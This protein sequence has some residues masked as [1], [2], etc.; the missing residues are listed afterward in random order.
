MDPLPHHLITEEAIRDLEQDAGA[1]AC[2]RIGTDRA[3]MREIPQDL[4]T[5]LYDRVA[6]FTLNVRDESD[7]ACVMLVGRVVKTLGPW[8][9]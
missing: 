3:A 6:F 9:T 7:A 5:L 8:Q 2:E 1:V 4:Q